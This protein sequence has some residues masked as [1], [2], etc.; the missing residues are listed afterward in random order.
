MVIASLK[1]KKLDDYMYN[2]RFGDINWKFKDQQGRL[3]QYTQAE[4]KAK[5]TEPDANDGRFKLKFSNLQPVWGNY[6]VVD[7]D[8][9][10]YAV[11]YSCRTLLF[12]RVKNEYVWVL[13]REGLDPITTE[14]KFK[15]YSQKAKDVLKMNAPDFD[16]DAKMRR[17][18]QGKENDCIYPDTDTD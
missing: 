4:G 11:I 9:D 8:Y 14:D 7:T 2:E 12:G 16:F 3:F 15:K 5:K 1:K 6:H 10:N 13:T 18:L 17:T